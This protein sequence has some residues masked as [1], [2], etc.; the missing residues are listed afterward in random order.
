MNSNNR[1][2]FRFEYKADDGEVYSGQFTTK[3]LSIKDRGRIGVKKSQLMG[4]MYCVRDDNNNPTG[5]GVDE[6][7]DYLNAMIAHLEVCLEQSPEWFNLEELADISVVHAVYKEVMDFEMSFFRSR[8]GRADSR[9]SEQVGNE[10]SSEKPQGTGPGN[11][12]TPVVDEKV[13]AALDA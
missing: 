4:G 2:T 8:D 13:Q 3:R 7:T 11:R 6:D 12:P 1:K 10:G 9:G 5:Q